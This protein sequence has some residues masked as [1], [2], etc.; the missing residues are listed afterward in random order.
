MGCKAV[1]PVC[2]INACKRSQYTLNAKKR[3]FAPGV[4]GSVSIFKHLKATLKRKGW[5]EQ[6]LKMKVECQN[7]ELVQST[8]LHNMHTVTRY[9]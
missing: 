8:G 2:T 9:S 3:G 4:S 6:K 7:E 1:G 5:K